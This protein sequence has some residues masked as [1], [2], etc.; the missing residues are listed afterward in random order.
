MLRPTGDQEAR[1][2]TNKGDWVRFFASEVFLSTQEDLAG[3][4]AGSAEM[5]GI[6]VDF[7]DSGDKPR[8]FAVVELATGQTIVV[9]VEKM[10]MARP[11]S[12]EEE[13]K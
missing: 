6:I 10:K 9:P 1:C 3:A 8:A 7:S 13:R 4:R 2:P 11:S 12:S 5:E